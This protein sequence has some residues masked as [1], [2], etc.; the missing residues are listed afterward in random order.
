VAQLHEVQ[1]QPLV[2]PTQEGYDRWAEIYDGEG[3]PL[4]ALEEPEVDRLL[5]DVAG[6]DVAD[7]GCGTGRHAI[8]LAARGANVTGVDFS[9][10]MLGRAQAK[11]GASA[12][13][14]VVH[15][16]TRLPLP[17]PERSF[18][19][20]LCALAVDHVAELPAFFAELGRLCRVDG[21]II[22]TVMHPALMLKGI[23]ARFHDPVS[24]RDTRPASVPNRIA[25]YVNGVLAAGLR[26]VEIGERDVDEALASRVP[27]AEKYLGW[28]M[29]LWLELAP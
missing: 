8:R 12:V 17:L 16:V 3:N 23:Q 9:E 13:R 18:D 24:G 27:R 4:I 6:L 15:D 10:G 5:G 11:E 28:P 19:R 7:V 14:W 20:V 21:R 29:L 25:D 26:I 2:L 1:D 22:V